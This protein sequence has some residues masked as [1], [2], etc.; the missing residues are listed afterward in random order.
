MTMTNSKLPQNIPTFSTP[1]PYNL[2]LKREFWFDYIPSGNPELDHLKMYI[3]WGT[4]LCGSEEK[5]REN[6]EK[7]KDPWYSPPA[8]TLNYVIGLSKPI[9][10]GVYYVSMYIQTYL[11]HWFLAI[12]NVYSYLKKK[13][14]FKF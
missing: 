13:F 3:T 9:F 14:V 10:L 6:D 11:A 5:R 1:R 7:S 4:G 12:C 2:Q 8:L